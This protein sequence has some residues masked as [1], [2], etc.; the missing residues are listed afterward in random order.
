M[1]VPDFGRGNNGTI[2]NCCRHGFHPFWPGIS[3]R[4]YTDEQLAAMNET[5]VPYN[6][7]LHTRYEINQ[8]QRALERKVRSAKRKYLAESEA[9]LDASR[10]AV[11]LK[12]AHQQLQQFIRDTGGKAD[13]S[14]T[15]VAGFGRSA[16]SKATWSNR[17]IID[18]ANRY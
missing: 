15:G 18:N 16:A 8:M 14:R 17:K 11:Q 12:A 4:N 7:K 5:N 13:S 3:K 2:K 9:G 10:S 1:I 6:G